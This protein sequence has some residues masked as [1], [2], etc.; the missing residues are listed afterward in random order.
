MGERAESSWVAAR[1]ANIG[2]TNIC[3]IEF[4]GAGR[5]R[6]RVGSAILTIC[7]Y[8]KKDLLC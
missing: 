4:A 8:N 1:S 2:A 3:A 5:F 7:V 6:C